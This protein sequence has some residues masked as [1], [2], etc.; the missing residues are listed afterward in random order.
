[1]RCCGRHFSSYHTATILALN[2]LGADIRTD[3]FGFPYELPVYVGSFFYGLWGLWLTWRLLQ[4]R[5]NDQIAGISVFY[6]TVATALAAYLWL[7]PDMS[8]VP[9][10][11]LISA[12]FYRLHLIER[13]QSL[14]L[15][16]WGIAGCLIGLIVAVRATDLWVVIAGL[17]IGLSILWNDISLW[18]RGFL[19]VLICGLGAFLCFL[20]QMIVWKSLYGGYLTRPPGGVSVDELEQPDLVG[21]LVSLRRGI[22]VWTPC[23]SF[24]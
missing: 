21:L 17:A 8:H 14:S 22:L 2:S 15:S 7:E 1:M 18:K 11:F 16:D 6:I 12:Y 20:P 3:G 23:Y 19:C 4:D 9:S 5:F 13:Q 24:P 10:M